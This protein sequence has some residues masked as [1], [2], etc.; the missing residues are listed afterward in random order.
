MIDGS[1]RRPQNSMLSSGGIKC[2]GPHPGEGAARST[3]ACQ[4]PPEKSSLRKKNLKPGIAPT[5]GAS[6]PGLTID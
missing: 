5:V 3:M 2:A 1:F 4:R 6:L